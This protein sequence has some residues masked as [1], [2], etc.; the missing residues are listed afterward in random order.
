LKVTVPSRRRVKTKV[1]MRKRQAAISGR[2]EACASTLYNVD[3]LPLRTCVTVTG[4]ARTGANPPPVDRTAA[5]LHNFPIPG[6]G[7][8]R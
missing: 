7:N 5:A 1:L 6:P 3:F 4:G 2:G 8:S